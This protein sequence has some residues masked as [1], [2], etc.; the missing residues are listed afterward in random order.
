M[1]DQADSG[2]DAWLVGYSG[3]PIDDMHDV[4][5]LACAEAEAD[6]LAEGW[7]AV[8][9]VLG[10]VDSTG[11]L[12]WPVEPGPRAR[13]FEAIERTRWHLAPGASEDRGGAN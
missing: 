10:Y 11:R 8:E 12:A 4:L 9:L 7:A 5:V 6:W 3:L 13:L 1:I 2:V